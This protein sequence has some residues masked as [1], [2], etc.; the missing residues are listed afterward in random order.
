MRTYELTFGIACVAYVKDMYQG[1]VD[2]LIYLKPEDIVV[3]KGRHDYPLM[4]FPL[5]DQVKVAAVLHFNAVFALPVEKRAAYLM[6]NRLI[7]IDVEDGQDT[8]IG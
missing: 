8:V 3:T 6:K 1:T 4:T 2:Q 7:T 5:P